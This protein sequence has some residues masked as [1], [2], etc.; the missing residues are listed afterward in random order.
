MIGGGA[1]VL[2]HLRIADGTT[3][4]AMSLVTR[5]ILEPGVYSSSMPVMPQ[6]EWLKA[7]AHL[8]RLP[9][10]SDKLRALTQAQAKDASE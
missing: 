4:Q 1:V 5:S 10:L 2:G 7:A 3:I 6:D 8:R 9:T